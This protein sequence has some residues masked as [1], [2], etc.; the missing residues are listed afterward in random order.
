M[1]SFALWYFGYDYKYEKRFNGNVND[2]L[3]RNFNY[4]IALE[5]SEGK[6]IPQS[7]FLYIDGYNDGKEL[8]KW[9]D[10]HLRGIDYFVAIPYYKEG[11][12]NRGERRG[13]DYWKGYIDGVYDNTSG[14]QIGFYWNLESCGQVKWGYITDYELNEL[15][16]YIRNE[17]YQQFIWIPSLGGRSIQQLED[18]GVQNTMKYFNYVFCQPNYYQRN[19]MQDGS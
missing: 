11:C 6:D 10:H 5:V 8:G 4:A 12:S 18:S 9:I 7:G 1:G 17:Q 16:N 19:T 14:Y 3:N 13:L 2:L 15:S